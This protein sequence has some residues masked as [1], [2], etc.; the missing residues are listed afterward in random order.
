[1]PL[2]TAYSNYAERIYNKSF[3]FGW[4]GW[5][6]ENET[7]PEIATDKSYSGSNSVRYLNGSA[8]SVYQYAPDGDRYS[9]FPSTFSLWAYAYPTMVGSNGSTISFWVLT[10]DSL[11]NAYL[12]AK[13]FSTETHLNVWYNYIVSDSDLGY[14]GMKDSNR[15]VYGFGVT[16]IGINISIWIDQLQYVSEIWEGA[17]TD[18]IVYSN[19]SGLNVSARIINWSDSVLNGGFEYGNT[20]NWLE[21]GGGELKYPGEAT[22]YLSSY[23]YEMPYNHLYVPG[24][25]ANATYSFT[26][27]LN[28]SVYDSV[29]FAY[30][31]HPDYPGW[32]I[33]VIRVYDDGTNS[34]DVY[35]EAPAYWKYEI[36]KH[37]GINKNIVALQFIAN[38]NIT[39]GYVSGYI[40]AVSM[41]PETA[42]WFPDYSTD[43]SFYADTAH[44][45]LIEDMDLHIPGWDFERWEMNESIINLA[46]GSQYSESHYAVFTG[47]TNVTW[48]Y[49][50]NETSYEESL[51]RYDLTINALNVADNSNISV[52]MKINDVEYYTPIAASLKAGIYIVQPENVGFNTTHYWKFL[53]WTDGADQTRT[54]NFTGPAS[55][56][57]YYRL[58]KIP[59]IG[60]YFNFFIGLFGLLLMGGSWFVL[61]WQWDEKEYA[62]AFSAWL[63][64]MMIGFGLCMVMFGA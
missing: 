63:S 33:T 38:S 49:A 17:R 58:T 54:I 47:A 39:D 43:F 16:A 2:A 30:R 45:Y 10:N 42:S 34:T 25:T 6:R 11:G 44:Y 8:L 46:D 9:T 1:M 35:S 31:C 41:I 15:W 20:V 37:T 29:I 19:P 21:S 61:K 56:T 5:I 28:S 13:E 59:D 14:M 3:E 18:V 55:Y 36:N 62:F 50:W 64:M 48:R 12:S 24:S 26:S 57:A 7:M 60:G 4:N 52:P 23:C 51:P 22:A 32:G 40:D 53:N 27:A